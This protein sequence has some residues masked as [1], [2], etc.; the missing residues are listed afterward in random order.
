MGHLT[1]KVGTA[2]KGV[3]C[4]IGCIVSNLDVIL[5]GVVSHLVNTDPKSL[6]LQNIWYCWQAD[7]HIN[8][9]S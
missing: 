8:R 5:M 9:L 6:L 1:R 7:L 4:A 3:A 2:V